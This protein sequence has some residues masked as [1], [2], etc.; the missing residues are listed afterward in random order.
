MHSEYRPQLVAQETS[1]EV[2]P[3]TAAA[4]PGPRCCCRRSRMVICAT[5]CGVP[6]PGLPGLPRTGGTIR[7]ETRCALSPARNGAPHARAARSWP[8]RYHLG[9]AHSGRTSA[10][11]L[12]GT[13]LH[14]CGLHSAYAGRMPVQK[15]KT[16]WDG[17]GNDWRRGVA[18]AAT[19]E[20]RQGDFAGVAGAIEQN[21]EA[22]AQGRGFWLGARGAAERMVNCWVIVRWLI[23]QGNL[24]GLPPSA[25]AHAFSSI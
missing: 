3:S 18:P 5:P 11:G 14:L 9:G 10:A 25:A 8:S 23:F 1:G 21:R 4:V 12:H 17:P 7:A 13:G 2:R 22:A 24:G 16:G 20:T 15:V 19:V 6:A